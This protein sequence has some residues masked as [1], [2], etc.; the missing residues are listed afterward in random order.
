MDNRQCLE[1]IYN[2]K[3]ILQ[4]LFNIISNTNS[5]SQNL[6]ESFNFLNSLLK[7][8]SVENLKIPVI[9]LHDGVVLT[10]NKYDEK[11]IR[12]TVLGELLLENLN[13]IFQH[14]DDD[15]DNTKAPSIEGTY[16]SSYKPLGFKR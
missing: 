10:S 12:N 8:A 14:F 11:L 15:S 16:G 3:N 1:I 9:T 13:T 6:A 7:L 5:N 4:N 2:D